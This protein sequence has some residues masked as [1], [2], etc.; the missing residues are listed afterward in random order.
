M[1]TFVNGS[2]VSKEKIEDC[3]TLYT[4]RKTYEN[5]LPVEDCFW[6]ALK[7]QTL[8]LLNLIT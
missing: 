1:K 4:E 8:P 5:I 3:Y 6:D 2:M 7:K